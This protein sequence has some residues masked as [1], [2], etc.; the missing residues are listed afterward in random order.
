[1]GTLRAFLLSHRRLAMLLLVA[2]LCLK[3]LMP[4]GYMLGTDGGRTITVSICADASGAHLTRAIVIPGKPAESAPAQAK[5]E[6]ACA[7]SGLA[8]AALSGAAFGL[9]ALALAFILALGFLPAVPPRLSRIVH[10]RPPLRGP[11]A[12]A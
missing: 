6:G 3:A 2:A 9:L 10:A 1:M 4:A 7:Y 11:P 12:F 5:G 8:M